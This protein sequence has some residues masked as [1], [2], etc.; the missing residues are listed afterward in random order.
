MCCK[1]KTNQQKISY[2]PSKSA[3][4]NE[5][6]LVP[7]DLDTTSL[8]YLNL[9]QMTPDVD[10]RKNVP[11]FKIIEGN[12]T[13][14]IVPFLPTLIKRS[15]VMVITEDSIFTD[16]KY[17]ITDLKKVMSSIFGHQKPS[18]FYNY[19]KFPNSARVA[20]NI[21]INSSGKDIK[22]M[23][24]TTTNAFDE[25]K[26]TINDSLH[27]IIYFDILRSLPEPKNN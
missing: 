11:Y 23:L 18:K 5:S 27:L 1:S 20:I 17:P 12:Q 2:Y 3:F 10:Y 6:F 22:K 25:V 4:E 13:K 8:N 16:K 24:I 21:D 14:N 9:V 26:N 7:I 19:D 15:E